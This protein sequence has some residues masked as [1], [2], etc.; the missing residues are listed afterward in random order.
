[1]RTLSAGAISAIAQQ[2][3]IW[4]HIG[5]KLIEKIDRLGTIT[6]C[7]AGDAHYTFMRRLFDFFIKIIHHSLNL[8]LT[9]AALQIDSH[10]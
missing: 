7:A 8:E 6:G 10:Y 5:Q 1:V 9:N 2:S 3:A 4:R